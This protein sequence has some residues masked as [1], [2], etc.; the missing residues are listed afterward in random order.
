MDTG[1][2]PVTRHSPILSECICNNVGKETDTSGRD[3]RC[4]GPKPISRRD[5]VL[6]KRVSALLEV[7]PSLGTQGKTQLTLLLAAIYGRA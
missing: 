2:E 5:D 3:E 1:G 7:D 4:R 6:H